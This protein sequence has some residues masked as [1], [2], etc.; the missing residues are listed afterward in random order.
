MT[1]SQSFRRAAVLAT[2]AALAVPLALIPA[3]AHADPQVPT[4]VNPGFESGAEGWVTDSSTGT[5]ASVETHGFDGAS[6]LTQW[7]PAAGRME[8]TQTLR[9]VHK[10]WWTFSAA[11]KAGGAVDASH[12]VFEGCG[13][14]GAVTIPSTE[15]DDAWLQLSVSGYASGGKDC[16]VGFVTEG[17]QGSWASIDAVSLRTGTVDRTYRGADFSQVPKNE[18]FGA[19]YL[20]KDGTVSDPVTILADAGANIGRLKVWVDP[21]DGYNDQQHVVAMAERIKAAGMK[22]LVD[23]HYSDRWTDPGAQGM[24]AAWA[25]HTPEQVAKDVAAHTTSVLTA[26]KEAGITADFVQVGNEINPGMLWPLGQTW[27]VH[28]ADGV[29]GAQWDNL[30]AF[31]TAGS[32]AVKAVDPSTKV[33]LHLTNINNG[34]GSLTWWFD[35]VTNRNV[36]FDII[37]LSYYSY[38]HGTFA[39]LQNAV[40]TLSARYDRDVLVVETA[41]PF[42][43]EDNQNAPW[44]N[45]IARSSQ[46]T[47]G[48]PATIAGQ[49]ANF[50]AVQDVVASAPGG[51]GLGAVYWEPAWTSVAGNGWD[52]A[53][54]SSG[55][56]WENQA[57][58]GYDG[59]VL[60]SVTAFAPDDR[61][62]RKPA[63]PGK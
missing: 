35:E 12:L 58:F 36:P 38:W 25:G 50:R 3:G 34:I 6:R 59:A 55:N 19:A 16:R 11:V 48:Y 5:V 60:D 53:D 44:E 37:G 46:L 49:Q 33:I 62:E 56:A 10:G 2:G 61:T 54:A 18:D 4:I 29:T 32:N 20:T 26:L 39:D 15:T 14:A 30:A 21:V 17:A 63:H 45:T 41:Y 9:H 7:L 24:P 51:R 13:S 40:S 31:L 43:L 1:L 23:F 8:T 57:M 27:D 22:L 47:R 42:T 28:P 52:P